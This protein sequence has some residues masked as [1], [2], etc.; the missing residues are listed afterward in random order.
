VS[1]ELAG[2][3]RLDLEEVARK[4]ELDER[5][6]WYRGR[7]AVLR[8]AL[9]QLAVRPGCPVLEVGCGTGSNLA[10]LAEVGPARGVE[11]NPGGLAW[12]RRAG[13][14]V[15]HAAAE[16]LPFGDGEFGLLA[17]LDVLE[18]VS[19][20]QAALAEMRRVTAPAGTLLL[21][22]PA[23]P[24]LFSEHDEAAGHRR[25]YGRA[26]LLGL[27]GRAGWEPALMTNFN[28][29]LLPVA[30]AARLARRFASLRGRRGTP[31]SDLL[32]TPPALDGALQW[33]IR[34]EAAA[35]RAGIR[36]PAGL[37]LLVG[38]RAE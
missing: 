6:W 37:S 11:L 32:R 3:P 17:C 14:T 4:A 20:D 9:T 31:R 30:A 12:A 35:I 7:R 29:L 23:Y 27:A 25:R 13:H 16:A 38:L 21:T 10:L 26:Q 18:H 36:L 19:D 24:G 33:P 28:L 5:H 34:G 2:V 1:S 8:A 22:V 15:D